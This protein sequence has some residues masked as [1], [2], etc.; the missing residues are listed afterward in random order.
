MLFIFTFR[1]SFKFNISFF[2]DGLTALHCAA[3]RGHTECIDTLISLC[4]AH[5]DLIDTNGC[6]ALHYAVTL[7]HADATSRLLDL[8][9]DPNR[10][11]RKGRT[12]AHCGCSKGQLETVK[13]LKDRSANLWLRNARGDLPLHEAAT[14]GRK[15][16]VEWLLE[17][18]P[19]N[20]NTTSNDGRTLLHIASSNAYADM[21]KMLL[22]F[23]ADVNSVYRNSKGVVLTSL[24]CALSRGHRTIA[25]FLQANG[26]LPASKLRLSARHPNA[27]NDQELV[28]PINYNET[29]L[30]IEKRKLYLEYRKDSDTGDGECSCTEHTY[31]KEHK[32]SHI[33]KHHRRKRNRRRTSS[34]GEENRGNGSGSD[35][36]RSKSNI[37]IRRRRSK[38]RDRLHSTDY[39]NRESEESNDSCENCCRHRRKVKTKR[40][41]RKQ[42][43]NMTFIKTPPRTPL[44][45]ELRVNV[46]EREDTTEVEGVDETL[47]RKTD[48]DENEKVDVQTLI[49]QADV[50]KADEVTPPG[51]EVVETTLE[52]VIEETVQAIIPEATEEIVKEDE[53]TNVGE[54][55]VDE[56][57][58]TSPEVDEQK[59]QQNEQIASEIKPP[60][61]T[62]VAV[63]NTSELPQ[64]ADI[65]E[66]NA[67]TIPQSLTGDVVDTETEN[68]LNTQSDTKEDDHRHETRRSFT[69]LP[70]G[71]VGISGHGA[72][73]KRGV[74][75]DENNSI[76]KSSFTVLKSDES[77]EVTEPT[78]QIVA[79]GGT[80]ALVSD[81][82]NAQSEVEFSSP[83]GKLASS[84]S[85]VGKRRK[86]KK[87]VKSGGKWK[88]SA[89]ENL[90][91]Q[92]SGFEPSP[93]AMRTKIPSPRNIYTA[94]I[95]RKPTFATLDNR[96]CSSRMENRKIGDKNACDM[97]SVTRSIQR[98][99]R[100][101]VK[102]FKLLI[103]G[104]LIF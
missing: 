50:H 60:E 67:A 57:Q 36:C 37:E 69:L 19:K 4:G 45:D 102:F 31:K 61:K 64:N 74:E 43:N 24:D 12:P 51:E 104:L 89:E 71:D 35:I 83:G 70:D 48:E 2:R 49:T 81:A 58:N 41:E 88:R 8:E 7:G 16:L 54:Q 10:Q 86:L 21:C 33:C 26:G 52:N 85:E 72:M 65:E 90:K 91:D 42:Q 27:F 23:G 47:E 30:D 103:L 55:V 25:K 11:D 76:R 14:S 13:L 82:G 95:P 63:D 80:A 28:K 62:K 44:V 77:V 100:R 92:D 56:N 98:N 22:D 96:S 34:C 97:T 93:R 20:I 1:Y 38:E 101:L 87:R 5:T 59:E 46:V 17:Q 68:I 75:N 3:S 94:Y 79:N 66:H 53:N 39:M 29:E 84:P 15:E 6:T 40:R 32:V 73:D 99:I 18:R 78:F 9:A